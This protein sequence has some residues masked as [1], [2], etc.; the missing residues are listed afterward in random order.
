MIKNIQVSS[1]NQLSIIFHLKM[2]CLDHW[3]RPVWDKKAE[4]FVHKSANSPESLESSE[5]SVVL[6]S[7]V[8]SAPK[9]KTW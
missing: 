5:S 8:D 3:S 7:L 1:I 6:L 4:L 9:N 2:V